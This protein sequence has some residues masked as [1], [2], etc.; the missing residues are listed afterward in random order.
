MEKLRHQMSLTVQKCLKVWTVHMV[1]KRMVIIGTM[2]IYRVTHLDETPSKHTN[3]HKKSS[4]AT[5][6]T[7]VSSKYMET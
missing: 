6:D 1:M 4:C 5:W 2:F 7:N 3:P